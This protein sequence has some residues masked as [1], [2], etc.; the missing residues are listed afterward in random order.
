MSDWYETLLDSDNYLP[1]CR[2]I[3]KEVLGVETKIADWWSDQKRATDLI[4]E[5]GERIAVRIRGHKHLRYRNEFTVRLSRPNHAPTEYS[6]L[7]ASTGPRY[8]FYG[9]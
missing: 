5:N 1:A 3:I 6:K 7:L 9:F 8:I 2:Q 4:G